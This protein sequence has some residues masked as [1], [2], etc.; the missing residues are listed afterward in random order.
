ML[1]VYQYFH[2]L[3]TDSGESDLFS[4]QG[5]PG[6]F[7]DGLSFTYSG[8]NV[9]IDE[10]TSRSGSEI[11]LRNPADTKGCAVG[12]SQY[13]Y[14]TIGASF[15]LGGL[16][17][18]TFP[19]TKQEYLLRVLNYFSILSGLLQ[20]TPSAG[21][22][23]QFSLRQNYPNPFN[24]STLIRFQNPTPG[25]FRLKISNLLGQSVQTIELGKLDPGWHK[26]RFHAE[27]L[28]SGIYFYRILGILEN[29]HRV[30]AVRKMFYTR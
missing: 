26:F 16:D 20:E 6:T 30:S 18:G 2:I 5:E 17:D 23:T 19:N 15:Q 14:H 3:C 12:Y 21:T 1:G 29:G 24:G 28:T 9:S 11:I 4:V 27:R 13:P 25:I 8:E 7:M 10:I 22:P